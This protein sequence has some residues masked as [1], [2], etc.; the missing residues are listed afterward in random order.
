MSSEEKKAVEEEGGGESAPLWIISF[1]DMIS[2]LMAFFVMLSSFN[3][4]DKV[5]K[6]KLEAIVDSALMECGGWMS[7]APN[8]SMSPGLSDMEDVTNGPEVPSLD[9]TRKADEI[10]QTYS[11]KFFTD[12]TFLVPAEFLF[13]SSGAALTTDGKQWLDGLS[14]YLS[15][16]TGQVLIAEKNTAQK[17]SSAPLRAIAVAEYL[18]TKNI[19]SGR[20]SIGKDGTA[21]YPPGEQQ[22]TMEISLLEK[23]ICP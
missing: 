6:K 3:E 18:V 12:K 20:I 13:Y 15:K 21:S 23:E 5:E 7:M 9:Q 4:F 14:V 11:K 17:I 8:S 22:Q 16:M 10:N 19:E 2:L 1:A